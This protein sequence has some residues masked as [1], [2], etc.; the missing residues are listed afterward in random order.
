MRLHGRIVQ[1][2]QYNSMI[3]NFDVFAHTS[4]VEV[5]AFMY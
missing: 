2:G 5:N 1:Y 4:A 3:D